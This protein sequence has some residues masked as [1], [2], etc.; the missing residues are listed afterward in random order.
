MLRAVILTI[1]AV[2]FAQP[3]FA[4]T[5]RPETAKYVKGYTG[6]EGVQIWTLRIGPKAANEALVQIG[7][8]DHQLDKRILRC[9]VQP[10][11]D[12]GKSY[13][14][15]NEGKNYVLLRLD[16]GAG[17]L[18]LPGEQPMKVVYSDDLSQQGEA[19]Y[20]LTEYLKQGE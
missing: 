11:S 15:E 16:H 13:L 4:E 7:R 20:F 5:V 14:I 6:E 17:E 1:C 9:K 3:V 2:L 10:I 18:Y 19:D 12:G 8:V